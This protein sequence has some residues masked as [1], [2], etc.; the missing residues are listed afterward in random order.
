MQHARSA[1]LR[2]VFSLA[3]LAAVE[4]PRVAAQ[5]SPAPSPPAAKPRQSVHGKLQSVEKRLSALVMTA[6]DGQRMVWKFPAPLVADAGER[7]KP[8]DSMIVIYR[9]LGP[10]TKRVTA[11]AFPGAAS[12]PTYV[13]YS[14]DRVTLRS[15]PLGADGE[16][17]PMPADPQQEV[18][19]PRE[20]TAELPDGCWCCTTAG[21]ACVPANKT[22]IGRALLVNCFE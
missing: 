1:V 13:N 22:G 6:D 15:A 19:I 10:S 7:F 12:T 11:V 9:Q 21:D 4:G 8:G 14:G 17:S 3:L 5:A 20:G 18:T 16:C 2:L